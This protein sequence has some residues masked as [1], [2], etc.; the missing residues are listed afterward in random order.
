M[1]LYKNLNIGML[2]KGGL[3]VDK[4]KIIKE[5]EKYKYTNSDDKLFDQDKKVNLPKSSKFLYSKLDPLGDVIEYRGKIYR[6]IKPHKIEY[7]KQLYKKGIIQT[8]ANNGIMPK[9]KISKFK[10]DIHPLVLEIQKVR[11]VPPAFWTYSMIKEEAIF[12]LEMLEILNHFNYTLIDGHP[13]NSTFIN[14]KPMFID[15]GSIIEGTNAKNAKVEIYLIN[16]IALLMFENND[17]FTR[18]Y[19]NTG[20]LSTLPTLSINE[21]KQFNTLLKEKVKETDLT[22]YE[23]FKTGDY[24]L[25]DFNKVF[26]KNYSNKDTLWSNY[27]ANLNTELVPDR[28]QKVID[29]IK[30]YSP[31]AKSLIDLAGNSGYFANWIRKQTKIK[32]IITTDFDENAV[33]SARKETTDISVFVLN[34]T[35]MSGRAD[36]FKSDAICALAVTHHI[37]LSNRYSIASMF[38]I[39]KQYTN[40]HIYVEFC[41]LGLWSEGQEIKIPTYYNEDWFEDNFKRFFK[42]IDKEVVQKVNINGKEYSHRVLYVGEIH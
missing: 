23:K 35:Q 41:P 31:N 27:R 34:F 14:D 18:T 12:K 36:L 21:Y 26:S 11:V 17:I 19:L 22:L 6:G 24:T 1:R 4:N 33:E 15:F 5:I 38:D 8:L 39:L 42:I 40:K 9:F 7:F 32:E 37:L 20:I 13:Y 2:N 10:T 28:Y 3:Q 30:Q 25:E 29:K 16:I